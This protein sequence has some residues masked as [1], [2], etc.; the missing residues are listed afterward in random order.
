MD[1]EL[2]KEVKIRLRSLVVSSPTQMDSRMLMRD[3][4]KMLG[5]H[6]P[7]AKMGYRDFVTFLRERCGD[8]FLVSTTFNL[9]NSILILWFPL[10]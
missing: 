2:V 3:Y 1:E 9:I 4:Y 10:A 5:T 6:I 7:L 8:S